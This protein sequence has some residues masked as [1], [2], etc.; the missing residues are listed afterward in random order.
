M[1]TK[2]KRITPRRWQIRLL[3]LLRLS[4][5]FEVKVNLSVGECADYVAKALPYQ[6]DS[7]RAGLPQGLEYTFEL[8]KSA[9][10]NRFALTK[11]F[12]GVKGGTVDAHLTGEM[13]EE[14]NLEITTI[15]AKIYPNFFIPAMGIFVTFGSLW[16][17]Y[18]VFNPP[19][20]VSLGIEPYITLGMLAICFTISIFSIR[21]LPE[22]KRAIK[23][24]FLAHLRDVIITPDSDPSV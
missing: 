4:S 16:M 5:S 20:G 21:S 19:Y 24:Y 7:I 17:N 3:D 11:I 23:S 9:D 12:R 18:Q 6:A 10:H 2:P 22:E 8:D 1:P 14:P 15:K 13:Q